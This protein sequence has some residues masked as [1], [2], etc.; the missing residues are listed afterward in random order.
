MTDPQC[1]VAYGKR[2]SIARAL[3]ARGCFKICRRPIVSSRRFPNTKSA[4]PFKRKPPALVIL[5]K[6][7]IAQMVAPSTFM[8]EFPLR[9]SI[10]M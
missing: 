3:N 6:I 8:A 5:P 1:R 2:G 9:T 7:M 10:L 4:G